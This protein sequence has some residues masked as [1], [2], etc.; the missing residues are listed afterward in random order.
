MINDIKSSSWKE[1]IKLLIDLGQFI[2]EKA[3]IT[4][5][6][7]ANDQ[8][9]TNQIVSNVISH[10]LL[11]DCKDEAI[12]GSLARLLKTVISEQN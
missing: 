1:L 3:N 10:S 6:N 2:N 4:A 9:S 8:A 11:P 5:T 12:L 7:I